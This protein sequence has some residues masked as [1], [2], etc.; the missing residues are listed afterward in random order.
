MSENMK[1]FI[2]FIVGMFIVLNVLTY[3][4]G[5]KDGDNGDQSNFGELWTVVMPGYYVGY[6]TLPTLRMKVF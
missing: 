4:F 3:T 6:Y 5:L 2:K 1:N